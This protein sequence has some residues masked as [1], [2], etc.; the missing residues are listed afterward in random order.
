MFISGKKVLIRVSE[1]TD[2]SIEED[3]LNLFGSKVD[4]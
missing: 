2:Y 4:L 3:G 1:I